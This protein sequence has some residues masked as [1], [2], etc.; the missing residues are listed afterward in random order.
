MKKLITLLLALVLSLGLTACGETG[1]TTY[2]ATHETLR[3]NNETI[4]EHDIDVDDIFFVLDGTA[5]QL[6]Y[7][8]QV[9]T[10][11]RENK[12]SLT[13]E[14]DEDPM[15]I[16][17]AVFSYSGLHSCKTNNKPDG[18]ELDLNYIYYYQGVNADVT[19]RFRL[20]E[21]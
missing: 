15:L 2:Y 16:D 8:V 13:L 6:H 18:Y 14:W 1:P 9:F 19:I 12:N 5:A 11:H 17:D 21:R 3:Y 20:Q 4:A 10:A 7:K